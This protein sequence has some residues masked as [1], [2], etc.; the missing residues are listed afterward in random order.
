MIKRKHESLLLVSEW[1]TFVKGSSKKRHFLLFCHNNYTY[2]LIRLKKSKRIILS[3]HFFLISILFFLLLFLVPH[4][5]MILIIILILIDFPNI[6]LL[7]IAIIRQNIQRRT[8]I[9]YDIYLLII[10]FFILLLI[11]LLRILYEIVVNYTIDCWIFF[12]LILMPH[13]DRMLTNPS[14]WVKWTALYEDYR[15]VFSRKRNIHSLS[16][17]IVNNFNG[18]RCYCRL[19]YIFLQILILITIILQWFFNNFPHPLLIQHF[20]IP[21]DITRYH[22]RGW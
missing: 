17:R 1:E 9:L 10:F 6:F 2:L 19:N 8:I 4:N 3:S 5:D 13:E 7:W 16:L 14:L 11:F 22:I 20:I 12:P 21:K 18:L 15:R